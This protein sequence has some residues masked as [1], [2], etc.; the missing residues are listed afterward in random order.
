VTLFHKLKI[1]GPPEK[2]SEATINLLLA[3][4]VEVVACGK[5]CGGDLGRVVTEAE[6]AQ[7][8]YFCIMSCTNS[9]SVRC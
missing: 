7:T 8:L 1:V 6:A 2:P 3:S 9:L 5:G 4:K